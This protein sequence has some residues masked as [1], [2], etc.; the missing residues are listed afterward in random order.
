MHTYVG[1]MTIYICRVNIVK[2]NFKAPLF[3][4]IVLF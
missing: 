1:I 4:K 2:D 3:Q